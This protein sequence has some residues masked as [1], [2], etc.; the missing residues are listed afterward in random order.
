[1]ILWFHR[2][3]FFRA[4][5]SPSEQETP[6]CPDV[7]AHKTDGVIVD[8]YVPAFTANSAN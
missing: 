2:S 7:P 3:T 5:P 6:L 1:V 4:L 8:P